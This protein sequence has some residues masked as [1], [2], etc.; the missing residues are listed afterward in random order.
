MSK[1]RSFIKYLEASISV[2]EVKDR[3]LAHNSLGAIY[4][5]DYY[6]KDE[7]FPEFQ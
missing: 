4:Q 5:V 3:A 6:Y 2:F 7:L 1:Y